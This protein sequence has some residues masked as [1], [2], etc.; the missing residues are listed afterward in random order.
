MNV[1]STVRQRHARAL[2]DATHA[3]YCG[4]LP[5]ALLQRARQS[6]AGR[7]H[8]V[9]AALRHAPEVFA[10]EQERWQCFEDAE[11]WLHWPQARLQ[12]FT[13][14]L[15]AIALGPALR[16]IVERS[17]VL[18]VRGALGTDHWQRAQRANPWPDGAPEAVRHMGEAVLQ[19][20]GCDAQALNAELY[21]RGQ[22]EF[23]GHAERQ[24][25]DL[26]ARL[27][28]AYAQVPARPCKVDTWL[29]ASALSAL[30]AAQQAL[31]A[32]AAALAMAEEE[33]SV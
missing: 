13:Q 8:L 22:I 30:L 17:A 15:G 24:H 21:E 23:I 19:R 9:R 18:F 1:E 32:A 26:A 10:P 20:C 2:L 27:V 7:R 3:A 25:P 6:P 11:P 5:E 31:D 16:M 4:D 12:A 14:E 29:P 28:L 33:G